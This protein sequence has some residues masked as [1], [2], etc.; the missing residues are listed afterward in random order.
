[1]LVKK[2]EARTMKEALE[3]VKAQM[4]PDAIILAARDNK[5][6]FGLV[7]EVSVEITAAVSETT[8]HKKK[9]VETKMVETDKERFQRSPARTQKDLI[10]KMVRRELESDLWQK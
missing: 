1:M 4:G 2:F 10:E 8:L 6:S 7:G 9:F 5:K 3:M